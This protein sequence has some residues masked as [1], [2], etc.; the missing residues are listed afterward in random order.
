M[1]PTR[2]FQAYRDKFKEITA[3]EET[4]YVAYLGAFLSDL[5][6]IDEAMAWKDD[7]GL[8]NFSKIQSVG[9][10]IKVRLFIRS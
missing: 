7:L 4:A 1:N 6:Y 5:I 10:A 8:I 3:V 2:G 9:S